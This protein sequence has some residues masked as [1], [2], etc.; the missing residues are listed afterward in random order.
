MTDQSVTPPPAYGSVE[1]FED[2]LR[3]SV[4]R[5][6]A[7]SADYML[8]VVEAL[9]GDF[10]RSD[11][12]TVQ[13]IRNAFAAAERVRKESAD[14]NGLDYSRPADGD[15]P[16]QIGQRE[17]L[18]TGAMTE[19]GLVDETADILAVLDMVIDTEAALETTL[20]RVKEE[21]E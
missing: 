1:S 15:D 9:V 2:Q 10:R 17:P 4:M 7:H 19:A 11:A 20:R 14:Q 5:D 8:G 3:R 18:H 21:G 13:F 16:Q 6:A 12:D